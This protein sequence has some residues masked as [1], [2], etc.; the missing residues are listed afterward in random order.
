MAASA[1]LGLS[2]LVIGESHMSAKEYLI[3]PLHDEL[4]KQGAIV[5]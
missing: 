4:T 3:N 5:H 2:L 1:L